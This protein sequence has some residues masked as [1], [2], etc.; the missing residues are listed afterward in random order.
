[1]SWGRH[2]CILVLY[3]PLRELDL[4]RISSLVTQNLNTSARPAPP[5]TRRGRRL[6]AG[7]RQRRA[8]GGALSTVVRGR[9]RERERERRVVIRPGRRRLPVWVCRALRRFVR[10]PSAE[11]A[12]GSICGGPGSVLSAAVV[13]APLRPPGAIFAPGVVETM[14][15]VSQR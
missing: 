9:F 8:A 6:W 11:R 7:E 1:M 12:A 3:T 14:R 5:P 13:A 2:L 15:G 10:L 4:A